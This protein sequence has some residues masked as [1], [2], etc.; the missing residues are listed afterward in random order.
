MSSLLFFWILSPILLGREG[1]RE[2]LCGAQQPAKL[3]HNSCRHW[4]KKKKQ[5]DIVFISAI[6]YFKSRILHLLFFELTV[7]S[8]SLFLWLI[9]AFLD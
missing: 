9:K 3:N 4:I 7:K 6:L 5:L 1:G 8:V 2:Q